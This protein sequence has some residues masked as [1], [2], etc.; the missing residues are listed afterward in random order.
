MTSC[1]ACGADTWEPRWD[2]LCH[3]RRCGFVRAANLLSAADVEGIY[4]ED[5]FSG[6]EYGDYLADRE[7]HVRNFAA[8]WRDMRRIAGEIPSVFEIGCAYGLFL[9]HASSQG[10][11]AAGIDVCRPA[12][13]HAAQRLGQRAIAGDFLSAPMAAG[14]YRAFCLW[15]TIEHLPHPEAV[16]A[17]VVELLPPGGWLFLTTGDIGSPLARLRGR[18]WRMIHPPSH[19]QYFSRHSMRQFLERH[20]LEVVEIRSISV[21]RTLHSV[22]S[23]LRALGRGFSRTAAVLLSR[24]VPVGVQQ[25]IGMEVNLG[26]IMLVAARRK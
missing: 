26:D 12:V 4:T 16:V 15:D 21:Y 18:R 17:R 24:T 19:L 8:R 10:A 1:I 23:G 11:I 14:E 5:Y 2:V 20:G 9:E 7:V 13:E 3:C 6:E 25:R 22:L